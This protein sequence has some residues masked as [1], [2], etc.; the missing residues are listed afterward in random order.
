VV[1]D[2]GRDEDKVSICECIKA[3]WTTC[4]LEFL[5]DSTDNILIIV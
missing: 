5:G 3:L 1:A 2:D 4:G